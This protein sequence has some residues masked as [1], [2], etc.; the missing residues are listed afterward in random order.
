M[1]TCISVG[2]GVLNIDAHIKLTLDKL[3]TIDGRVPIVAGA[4]FF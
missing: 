4:L 2:V 3:N 1:F